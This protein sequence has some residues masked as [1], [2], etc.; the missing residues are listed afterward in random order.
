MMSKFYKCRY[1]KFVTLSIDEITRHE[2]QHEN[3][4]SPKPCC[5]NCTH[6]T[7]E[8][9][10]KHMFTCDVEIITRHNLGYPFKCKFDCSYH[11]FK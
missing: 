9:K 1:C 11:V 8:D 2:K 4:K 6:G 3:K 10:I 5:Y 7:L